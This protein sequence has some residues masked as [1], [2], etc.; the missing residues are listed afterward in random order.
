MF[1]SLFLSQKATVLLKE[2]L[3]I[4]M[5]T[6]RDLSPEVTKTEGRL[7]VTE[8]VKGHTNRAHMKP[9]QVQPLA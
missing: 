3:G 5:A 1:W 7:E 4:R 9:K 6:C 8:W 2:G